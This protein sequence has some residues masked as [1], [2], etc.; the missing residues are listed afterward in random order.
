M[1][2][3]DLNADVG[4]GTGQEPA[5][6]PLITSANVACGGH[7]GDRATMAACVA[8]ARRHRVAVGAHPGLEDRDGF[9]RRELAVT[10]LEAH[11]LV[12]TQVRQLERLT[13][14]AGVPLEHVKPH[15]ALYHLAARD[16]NLACA[17]AE[18]VATVDPR[19]ILFGL[20]GSRLLE[21]GRVAGLNV[22]S[23]VFA[24]RTYR[25][26]GTLTPRD[27][28]DA[29]IHDP[30]VAAGRVLAMVLRGEV[31]ATDG[32]VIRVAAETVCV[33]GDSPQ[34]VRLARQLRAALTQAGVEVRPC[35]PCSSSSES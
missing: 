13:A 21:A 2:W 7:A 22:A 34:A 17:V 27:R 19:L 11:E 33:H 5:L 18:A 31:E 35:G 3:V 6:M 14:E 24:D 20:A 10:P 26:D 28:P 29:L 16:P 1:P 25:P 9:G 12:V 4:E 32:T 30:G 15:G 8:L 23:E